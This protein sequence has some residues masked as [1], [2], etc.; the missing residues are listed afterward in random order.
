[1]SNREQRA[2]SKSIEKFIN[3]IWEAFELPS[4][5][6]PRLPTREEERDEA[7]EI[8]QE[9]ILDVAAEAMEDAARF[10]YRRGAING[11]RAVD[12]L[13]QERNEKTSQPPAR[14]WK[15]A[16]EAQYGKANED[17]AAEEDPW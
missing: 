16:V 11:V 17:F 2:S 1:M 9:L 10:Y 5:L 13:R 15:K 7:I 14:G 8:L 6:R 4:E 3:A 12:Q